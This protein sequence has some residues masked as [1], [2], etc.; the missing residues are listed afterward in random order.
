MI[1]T[2]KL[3]SKKCLFL[4]IFRLNQIISLIKKYYIK[5][6]RNNLPIFGISDQDIENLYTSKTD[7][8]QGILKP[9]PS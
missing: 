8:Y 3:N 5:K 6:E 2:L 9:L 1:C 4:F 7:F